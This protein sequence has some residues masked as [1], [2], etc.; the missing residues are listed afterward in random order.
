[1][2]LQNFKGINSPS[3]TGFV[4]IPS[5]DPSHATGKGGDPATADFRQ[6]ASPN[7]PPIVERHFNRGDAEVPSGGKGKVDTPFSDASRKF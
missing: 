5:A 4:S 1:M 3:E 7:I 2:A 6:T